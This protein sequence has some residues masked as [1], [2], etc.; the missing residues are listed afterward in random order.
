[1]SDEK[2]QA[3]T[4]LS[5]AKNFLH[6]I[7]SHNESNKGQYFTKGGGLVGTMISSL[8]YSPSTNLRELG[9]IIDKFSSDV[10]KQC[11][12]RGFKMQGLFRKVYDKHGNGTK[13]FES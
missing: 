8:Q 6:G 4:M 2:W 11:Y 7:E 5:E 9:Q 10:S 1:M 12:S 3:F 13:A